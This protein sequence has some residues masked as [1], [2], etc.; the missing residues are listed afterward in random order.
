MIY[1]K[2]LSAQDYC[3]LTRE[4]SRLGFERITPKTWTHATGASV[5]IDVRNHEIAI[6]R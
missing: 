3:T 5:Q 6:A 4:L 1:K 2:N